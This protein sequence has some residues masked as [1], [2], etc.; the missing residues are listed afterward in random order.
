MPGAIN[1]T[2]PPSARQ[3]YFICST[4]R[5]AATINIL[6][7]NGTLSQCSMGAGSFTINTAR[8]ALGTHFSYPYYRCVQRLERP[9]EHRSLVS[10]HSLDHGGCPSAAGPVSAF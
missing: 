3:F 8:I 5:V 2:A 9:V 6:V 4:I 10:L 7:S 1:D